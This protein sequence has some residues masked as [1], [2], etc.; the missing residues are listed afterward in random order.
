MLLVEPG[1]DVSAAPP[2]PHIDSVFSVNGEALPADHNYGLYAALSKLCPSIHD[3]SKLA[4][5]TIAG[6]PDRQGKIALAPWSKLRLRMPSESLPK[7]CVLAGKQLTIGSYTIRLGN[8]QI[9]LLQPADTL[10]ARLVTIKG[11]QEPEEFLG[12]LD[13]Q[14]TALGIQALAGIPSDESGH[15][16]RLTLRIKRHTVIGFSVVVTELSPE[17]SI[18]LQIEGLGGKRRM[19]CG[20]FVRESS[21]LSAVG[22][23]RHADA[24]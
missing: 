1:R 6:I 16:K 23:D 9:Q 21:I 22:G 18:R 20:V 11:Y 13:R 8:P 3:E 5:Q 2:L 7:I 12:A 4:I 10:W 15:P 24:N 19:G 17:D 14:M